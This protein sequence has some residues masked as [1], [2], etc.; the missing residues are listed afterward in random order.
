M[1]GKDERGQRPR[2]TRFEDVLQVNA[3]SE[4]RRIVA[5]VPGTMAVIDRAGPRAVLFQCPCTC[6]DTLVINVDPG[7]GKAWRLRVDRSGL[8]LMPSVWRTSGCRSHFILWRNQV[9]WCDWYDEEDEDEPSWPVEM[10]GELKAEW[11]RIRAGEKEPNSP[12]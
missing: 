12:Q 6:G 4:A 3:Q 1:S 11:R 9:W 2:R 10:D 5:L 7:A 8:S